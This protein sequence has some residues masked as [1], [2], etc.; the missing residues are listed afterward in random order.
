M[1]ALTSEYKVSLYYFINVWNMMLSY[2]HCMY[3]LFILCGKR[4]GQI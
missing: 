3:P 4:E 2:P 1:S